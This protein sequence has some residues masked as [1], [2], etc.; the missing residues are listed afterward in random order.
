MTILDEILSVKKDEVA[1]L[2]KQ[3]SLN[4]FKEMEYF[5]RPTLSFIK[6]VNKDSNVSIIAEVKKASPSKGL[7]KKDFNH[8][9][10]AEEYFSAGVNAVS[11]LTDE[12]FFQGN[13]SYLNDIAAIKEVPLLRKDF[14][15]DEYQI[16]EAKGN[17]ADLILLIC[18]ALSKAQVDALSHAAFECGL[19]VLLELHSAEQ[20]EKINF[21]VNKIIGVNN[22]N[23]KTFVVDLN[24][25]AE[26]SKIIKK[27]TILVSESGISKKEDL[28]FLKNYNINAVLVGEH[29]MRSENIKAKVNEL[30]EWCSNNPEKT[31]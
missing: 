10:I 4:S 13:I 16:F 18:E 30:K 8:L 9:K 31:K 15:I 23:L 5:E 17:G 25:T 19:E 1:K 27:D 29:L 2:K 22:R 20:I 14:I 21:D 7:I 11:V 28:N 3:Y 26:L 24:T 12:K 6:E